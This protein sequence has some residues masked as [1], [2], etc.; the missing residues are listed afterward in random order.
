MLGAHG[1]IV[2]TAAH[3]AADLGASLV[4]TAGRDAEE[5]AEHVRCSALV[6]RDPPR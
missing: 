2:A 5:V 3:A 1:K 6:L 4:V